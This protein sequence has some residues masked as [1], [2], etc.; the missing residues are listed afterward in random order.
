MSRRLGP[1][2]SGTGDAD[3]LDGPDPRALPIESVLQD[4]GDVSHPAR[5]PTTQNGSFLI[6]NSHHNNIDFS[7]EPFWCEI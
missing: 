5:Q 4:R 1:S 3:G 6:V 7:D 2:V